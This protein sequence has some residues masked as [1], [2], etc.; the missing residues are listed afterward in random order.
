MFQLLIMKRRELRTRVHLVAAQERGRG[1]GSSWSERTRAH[2]GVEG[3][4]RRKIVLVPAGEHQQR[5]HTH[6]T[7]PGAAETPDG[8]VSAAHLQVFHLRDKM[9]E[10]DCDGPVH[11]LCPALLEGGG[12]P[13]E[14]RCQSQCLFQQ[15]CIEGP[16]AALIFPCR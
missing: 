13:S 3:W 9:V 10:V 5:Q 7:K 11:A 2:G 16:P 6:A 15:G 12:R 1:R 14:I 8:G 4:R